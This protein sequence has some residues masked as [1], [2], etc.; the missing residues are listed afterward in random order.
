M[1]LSALLQRASLIY[2]H[3]LAY[4]HTYYSTV[5][6]V[7]WIVSQPFSLRRLTQYRGLLT[8]FHSIP[9]YETF[10]IL[11]P[12]TYPPQ[13][14]QL[15]NSTNHQHHEFPMLHTLHQYISQIQWQYSSVDKRRKKQ[16]KTIKIYSFHI[17]ALRY[18]K[19]EILTPSEALFRAICA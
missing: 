18:H 5:V 14:H 17:R 13:N 3:F 12:K 16:V 15:R 1:S 7:Q 10:S 2:L 19:K 9:H 8:Q 6:Y 4:M 11:I